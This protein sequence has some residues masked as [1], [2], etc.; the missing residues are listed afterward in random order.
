[1]NSNT[2]NKRSAERLEH[3]V[4]VAYRTIDSF[5]SDFGTNL[6]HKG[7]FV[8]TAQPLPVGTPVRLLVSLPNQESPCEVNGRVTRVQNAE[9]DLTPGMGI[10]F[11]EMDPETA[12]RIAEIVNSLRDKLGQ[13]HSGG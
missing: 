12:E 7:V 8:N 3:P 4:L 2:D 5:L 13:G 10:E 1:M 11:I 9:G 6:S